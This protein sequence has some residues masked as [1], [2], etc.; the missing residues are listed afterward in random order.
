M[1]FF[2]LVRCNKQVLSTVLMA[3]LLH[4]ETKQRLQVS[5]SEQNDPTMMFLETVRFKKRRSNVTKIES[6]LNLIWTVCNKSLKW[7][8]ILVDDPLL[9]VK[10]LISKEFVVGVGLLCRHDFNWTRAKRRVLLRRFQVFFKYQKRSLFTRRRVLVYSEF[11][12]T[13][14]LNLYLGFK[15]SLFYIMVMS[16]L[17]HLICMKTLGAYRN[18]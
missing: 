5:R 8:N 10:Y 4:G 7:M 18:C 1:F 11:C 12:F 15:S 3:R 13:I 6:I 14:W 9:W 2:P 16:V 17:F